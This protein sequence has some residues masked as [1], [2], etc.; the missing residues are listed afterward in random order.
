MGQTFYACAYDIENKTCCV[1]DVDKFHANCYCYSGAA[2]SIHYLLRQKPYHVMWGG[3]YVAID[4]NL[5]HFSRTEDLLGISTYMDYE[6]FERNIDE[7]PNKTY[8][9]KTKF[10]GEN[11]KLWNRIDVWDEALKYFDG[12]HDHTV[13]YTGYLVNHTKK[14]AVDLADYSKRSASMDQTGIISTIDA[15]PVLTETGG[16]TQ[17]ALFNGLS[18]DTTEVLSGTW[19]GD[20]LEIV[21]ELSEGY[22]IINCCFADVQERTKYCYRTFGINEQGY[23]LGG[24]NG[25]LFEGTALSVRGKRGLSSYVKVEADGYMM[26]FI[27]VPVPQTG[28]KT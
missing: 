22:E 26:K 5:E 15:V 28:S 3:V 9:D 2:F 4:D 25:R 10:I 19:C 13:K 6:D 24:E 16:G 1:M 21:D 14:K 7:L 23:V 17:M 20:L 27:P 8:Y 18:A 12:A 11:Y